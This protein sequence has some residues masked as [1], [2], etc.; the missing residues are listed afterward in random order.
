MNAERVKTDVLVIGGGAAGCA[1][2]LE[3]KARGARPLIVVKGRMGRSGATP[4]ASCLGAPAPMP[5]PYPLLRLMKRIYS[6]ASRVVP[7]PVPAAY[8]D[9]MRQMLDFHYWLVDQDYFLDWAMWTAK[10]FYPELERSGIYVLRD[11][12][13]VPDS[14]PDGSYHV[15]HTHGMTG[16]QYGESKR[17]EVLAA[18]IEVLE[19]ASAFALLGGESGE[20]SGA[21]VLDY[22]RGRLL[23]VEAKATVLATGHTNWLS[24]RATGT[25]EMAANGLAM[26]ARAGAALSNLEIQWFHASDMAEP[27]SW[28]RLHSYPNPLNGTAHRAV[29][30]NEAD[31]VF[32]NI[33]DFDTVMPYTI[34]MKKLREQVRQ[35]K[36]RWDGGSYTDY[37]R[38]EPEALEKYQY[39][40][41]F[42]EKLGRDM[43]RDRFESAVTW[44][45]SA[46]GVRA[47]P[48]TM[49]T[50]VARLYI[51]GAV[52]SHMLGGLPLA[53]YDGHLAGAGAARSARR[54]GSPPGCDDEVRTQ[55]RRIAELLSAPAGD[56][57]APS[58]IAVKRRIR[59][60]VW[61]DMM[62]EKSAAG[63]DRALASLAAL[64]EEAL[65]A[66]QVRSRSRRYN[67]DLVD[68]LDVEDML[69]VCEMA[70]HASRSREES[71]GPHFR[72]EF[73]F[74]DNENWIRQ[75]VVRREGGQ[76]RVRREPVRL[77]YLR[78]KAE[79]VDYFAEPFA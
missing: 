16:Y 69:D 10:R 9:A 21:M 76:V 48:R 18:G 36:A 1:A 41:E 32:M 63:L 77:K 49:E 61:R 68:A 53:A 64:R 19:E 46:G 14:P 52:G 45:M 75:V 56:R 29:M 44:H 17:K 47:D 67:V 43:A 55:E 33:E 57:N 7:L 28:M 27:E 38:V 13:G 74:T 79:K 15:I 2:A 71:R 66:L 31:E 54:M 65:P 5:G 12:E 58:P 23:A 30:S 70:A 35:G 50:G 24:R 22:A 8:A 42:Y 34:Q 25:R 37:R 40:F 4:L 3:A 60:V 11:E 73:P 72:T 51:A 39:H 78:P 6:A 26:A 20:V 62:Y 59:E